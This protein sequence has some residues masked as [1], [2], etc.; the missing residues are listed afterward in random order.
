MEQFVVT[1]QISLSKLGVNCKG[2][3]MP[4]VS[5]KYITATIVTRREP[6]HVLFPKTV[7]FDGG[8]VWTW[9]L[10]TSTWFKMSSRYSQLFGAYLLGQKQIL[11]CTGTIVLDSFSVPLPADQRQARSRQQSP[12]TLWACP[13]HWSYI[14]ASGCGLDHLA[15]SYSFCSCCQGIPDLNEVKNIQ[16]Y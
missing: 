13:A 5:W 9:T 16:R 6:W 14:E 10:Q 3:A 2:I 15:C 4:S 7:D 8:S 12:K 1:I 11:V